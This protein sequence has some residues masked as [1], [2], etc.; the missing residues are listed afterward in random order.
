MGSPTETVKLPRPAWVDE[1]LS[2]MHKMPD[3]MR[4]AQIAGAERQKV[5]QIRASRELLANELKSAQ[6]R[7][8]E[9]ELKVDELEQI[10]IKHLKGNK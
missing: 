3:A 10:I 6:S 8:V 4:L 9:L 2:A 7:I 5:E 1:I